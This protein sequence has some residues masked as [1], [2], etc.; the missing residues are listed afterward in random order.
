[1]I[2]HTDLSRNQLR[3]MLQSG[4]LTLAGN[5][6]LRIY[7]QI[8]CASGKRMKKENRVFFHDARQAEQEGFRPCGRCMPAG[9]RRWQST[10]GSAK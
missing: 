7:G 5:R 6:K 9:Y 10:K 4:Q 3:D 8:S 2:A 1:M